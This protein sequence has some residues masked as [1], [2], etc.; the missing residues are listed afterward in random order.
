M[1]LEDFPL[2]RQ[3]CPL[4]IESCKIYCERCRNSYSC[5]YSLFNFCTDGYSIKDIYYEWNEGGTSVTI[6]DDINLAQF[7]IL[8]KPY[9]IERIIGLSTGTVNRSNI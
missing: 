2:D 1:S 4:E 5:S 3:N 8:G 7:S 9:S 6:A